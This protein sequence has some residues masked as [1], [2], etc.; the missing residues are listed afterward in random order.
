MLQQTSRN[1]LS[2]RLRNPRGCLLKA[3]RYIFSAGRH[4]VKK[5]PVG[6]AYSRLFHTTPY[7]YGIVPFNLA[8][9]G[10]G[11]AEVEIMQWFVKDGDEVNEFDEICEVQSDKAT[12]SITSRYAGKITKVHYDVGD[13]AQVGKPLID[14]DVDGMGSRHVLQ[15]CVGCWFQSPKVFL[16]KPN[17][18]G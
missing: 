7:A 11:I 9:I 1:M 13:L 14:I 10:E 15:V 6:Q 8:D 12:V 2:S 18:L 5:F 3:A 17:Y 16:L 4:K